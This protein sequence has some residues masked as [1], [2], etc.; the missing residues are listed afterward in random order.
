MAEPAI[1]VVVPVYKVEQYIKICVESI[2]AQTFTNFEIILV[3]DATPDK[4]FE[5]CEK[6]YGGNEKFRLVRHEKNLGLGPARNTGI[7]HARGKYIYF[8][9]SD[10]LI[11]PAALEKFF[12][13]AEKNN[14]QIVRA[15]GYYSIYQTEPAPVRD[16]D[17]KIH[18]TKFNREGFL[19]NDMIYRFDY[20]W[21]RRGLNPNVWCC[22]YRRDFLEENRLEFLPIICED[23]PF[24]LATL[25]L[26]ERYYILRE[27]LYIY[28]RR[29][30]SI[31]T[32][33]EPRRLSGAI[34]AMIV[35]LDYIKN[36]LERLPDTDENKI[37]RNNLLMSYIDVFFIK[38]STLPFYHGMSVP[39][40]T[41][42]VVEESLKKFFGNGAN[43]VKYFFD[44]YHVYRRRAEQL[45]AGS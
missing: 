16:E 10:D 28:R 34:E 43:F 6:F 13:A 17:L 44:G 41:S 31:T 1:S 2:L 24:H 35:G 30:N 45:A 40:Q 15:S 7:K 23:I 20:L 11:L 29:E 8:A 3:D 38:Q 21:R 5:L 39:V 37:L 33:T 42:T 14:A 22:L 27:A 9:D 4:S 36:F 25:G 12:N 18:W 19:P 26:A 32:T